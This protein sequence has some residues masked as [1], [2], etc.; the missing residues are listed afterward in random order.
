MH[1]QNI[2]KVEGDWLW[3]QNF[4]VYSYCD[5][6]YKKTPIVKLKDSHVN[7]IGQFQ[8]CLGVLLGL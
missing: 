8:D 1:I 7:Y 2:G 4:N 3:D 6:F 5:F